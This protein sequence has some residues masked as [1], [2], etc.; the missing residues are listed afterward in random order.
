MKDEIKIA[1]VA[2]VL[3]MGVVI[4]FKNVIH[5]PSDVIHLFF[6]P[7]FLYTGY[8]TGKAGVKVWIGV[9]LFVT[10]GIAALYAFF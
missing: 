8:I 10:L 7:V 4:F 5:K 3:T 9:T 2:A 6:I 1:I